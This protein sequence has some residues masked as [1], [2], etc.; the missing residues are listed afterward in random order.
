[1]QSKELRHK[2]SELTVRAARLDGAR[3]TD[4]AHLDTLTQKLALAKGRLNLGEEVSVIFNALQERAHQRSVGAFERLLSAFLGD[5]L[6]EE[7]K[8][9]LLPQFKSSA[10][11]LDIALEKGGHLED[12]VD[13][14]GGAVTNVICTGLRFAA[15]SR[16][17]NRR[18]MILDESDCWLKPE[19]VPAFVQ[20]V[21]QV[22]SQ[23]NTQTFFITHH[24]P[25]LFEGRVNLV[26]FQGDG[27]AEGKV[28]AHAMNPVVSEWVD[29]T[30]P[31]I[32]AIELFNVRR[33]A[34]TFVP[35]FPHA[36]AFIGDNNLG[37]STAVVSSFKAVAYGESDDSII[38]HGCDEARIIFY[39]ENS[40]RIEWSRSRK[41][42]PSVLYRHYRGEELLAEG[43]PKARNQAPDWVVE[44]LGI[45]RVDDLDIQVGNQKSPV[46]LLNDSA[47]RRAQILSVGR[48]SSHLR[49]F[50]K[51]YE[52][53][54]S[55][56]RETVK[57]GELDVTRL[58]AR[59]GY[60]QKTTVASAKLE[61]LNAGADE[62]LTAWESQEK[63]SAYLEKLQTSETALLRL[64]LEAKA[65][66]NLPSEPV[67]ADTSTM[68]QL[69]ARL[70][71][72]SP[73]AGLVSPPQIAAAPILE[74]EGKLASLVS[75]IERLGKVAG[76]T[77]PEVLPA[78]PEIYDLSNLRQMGIRI[79][80]A[81]KF[82]D[83]AQALPE[84]PVLPELV[85]LADMEAYLT[86]MASKQ[87]ELAGY[88]RELT[89]AQKEVAEAEHK[90]SE[91]LEE[92]GGACPLCG[93]MTAKEGIL[94]HAH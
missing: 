76:L 19:R 68:G 59:L 2:L 60:L 5:V 93:S 70:E 64:E 18:L 11:W 65:L 79:A 42:S 74:D 34:H 48:E 20:V 54:R 72:H 61:Q 86:R 4:Q 10:T 88:E 78:V 69:L 3:L 17:D 27:T 38:R 77:P 7:G 47:P 45:A 49:N 91:L 41:R 84:V 23:T 16:T 12:V 21:A 55:A 9:R 50:M 46:F 89:T 44:V 73:V 40:E 36:T 37:K 14:N 63:L 39:L 56:D 87:T 92:S 51:K 33:H 82:L 71:R 67:L 24:D 26:K 75:Q 29:D 53:A 66:A 28:T 85:N 52:E 58:K 13:A 30:Q 94:H 31:G 80:T 43:R 22:A 81:Q 83:V 1:M 90:V 25:A 35:C 62:V 8:V 57:A 6:P 32:R 15:L